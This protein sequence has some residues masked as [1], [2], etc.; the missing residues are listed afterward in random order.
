MECRNCGSPILEGDRFCSKCG[1][2][3]SAEFTGEMAN[4]EAS[5]AGASGAETPSAEVSSEEAPWAGASNAETSSTEASSAGTL[6]AGTPSADASRTEA[7][8]AVAIPLCI[9]EEVPSRF[10]GLWKRMFQGKKAAVDADRSKK[11]I[12]RVIAVILAAAAVLLIAD[13][14]KLINSYH[15][16]FSTPE[17]YYRWVERRA[18]HTNAK[19]FAGYYANYIMGYLRGYDSRTSG[20]IR[21]ELG[22]AG[23]ELLE[24]AGLEPWFEEGAL[25][26]ETTCRDGVEQSI[27]GLEIEGEKLFGLDAVMDLRDEA[28]YLGLPELT[29]KYLA[30]DTEGKD[31]IREFENVF[32][33]EP[34]EYLKEL[35]LLEAFYEECPDKQQMEALADRYLERLLDSIDDV[36]MRTGKTARVGGVTQTCTTLE[37]Y[38][39]KDDIRNM[40]S[41]FLRELR[42]DSEI[43]ALLYQAYELMEEL[44]PEESL[45]SDADDFYEAYQDRIDEILDNMDYYI[46]YHNELDMTVYVDDKGRIIGRTMEFPNSWDEITVSYLFPRRGSRFGYK[47]S[48]VSDGEEMSVTGSGRELWKKIDG[49]FTVK[50]DGIG[51][52]DVDV[53][54]FDLKSLQKG[55]LNGC[56]T[57]SAASGIRRMGDM[58][59][60]RSFLPELQL[61]LDVSMDHSSRKLGIELREGRDLWGILTMTARS[62]DGKKIAVPSTKRAIFVEDERDLAEWW[63]TIEWEKLIRDMD[64]AGVPSDTIERVEKFSGMDAGELMEELRELMCEKH[65]PFLLIEYDK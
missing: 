42:E 36:K 4:A 57:V 30:L 13:S 64:K 61:I 43:E 5:R 63:D 12:P 32:G 27:L 19:T 10:Q 35:E 8:S 24:S 16:N 28:V 1:T 33:V 37:I 15:R 58:G 60:A 48:F 44:D 21:L 34:E 18:I 50:Y 59:M 41:G 47:A 62:G 20:E 52:L 9:P 3:V 6:S 65:F 54:D 7:S 17:E 49:R 31:F 56:F 40:L 46:T 11:R 55:F 25:T 2:R 53:E 14:A 38:L 39:D 22:N 26:Y 23:R 29:E 45:Y 51:I